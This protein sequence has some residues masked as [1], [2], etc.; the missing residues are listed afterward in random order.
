MPVAEAMASGVAVITS[1]N[2]AM[3]EVARNN[4]AL[5]NPLDIGQISEMMQ[6][7]LTQKEARDSLIDNYSSIVSQWSWH[8][9]ADTLTTLFQTLK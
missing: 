4:T 6:Y 3:S 1:E 7:Y 9:S 2:S 5:V 8:K